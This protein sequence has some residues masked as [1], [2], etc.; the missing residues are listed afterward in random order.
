[1]KLQR[2][3]PGFYDRK[4]TVEEIKKYLLPSAKQLLKQIA[5]AYA[6]SAVPEQIQALINQVNMLN[7]VPPTTPRWLLGLYGIYENGQFL[8]VE[9]SDPNWSVPQTA[10]NYASSKWSVEVI[11]RAMYF[12]LSLTLYNMFYEYDK[13]TPVNTYNLALEETFDPI[14]KELTT[15]RNFVNSEE[16]TEHAIEQMTA[17]LQKFGIV[18]E[19]NRVKR[20]QSGDYVSTYIAAS[21]Y[22]NLY[23][24]RGQEEDEDKAEEIYREWLNKPKPVQ[25]D[26]ASLLS[27][28]YVRYDQLHATFQGLPVV[29]TYLP[30][31]EYDPLEFV[32]PLNELGNVVAKFRVAWG[33]SVFEQAPMAPDELQKQAR[34]ILKEHSAPFPYAMTPML[35]LQDKETWGILKQ[36]ILNLLKRDWDVEEQVRLK[37]YTREESESLTIL[38]NLKNLLVRLEWFIVHGLPRPD[39]VYNFDR[40]MS[41]EQWKVLKRFLDAV[42]M[43]ASGDHVLKTT[44]RALESAKSLQVP[45]QKY[46]RQVIYAIMALVDDLVTVDNIE[47]WQ[48]S[49]KEK[50]DILSDTE[51]LIVQYTQE[52][53]DPQDDSLFK[54]LKKWV[55]GGPWLPWR[56]KSKEEVPR[57]ILDPDFTLAESTLNVFVKSKEPL[58]DFYIGKIN[59]NFMSALGEF[60][61]KATPMSQYQEDILEQALELSGQKGINK[62]ELIDSFDK[63]EHDI[64]YVPKSIY[65]EIQHDLTKACVLLLQIIENLFAGIAVF[66]IQTIDA[67]LVEL[68]ALDLLFGKNYRV[69]KGTGEIQWG[70][71]PTQIGAPIVTEDHVDWDY[72][73]SPSIIEPILDRVQKLSPAQRQRLTDYITLDQMVA[74]GMIRPDIGFVTGITHST[75]PSLTKKYIVGHQ[76]PLTGYYDFRLTLEEELRLLNKWQVVSKLLEQLEKGEPA[77]PV[78][79][80]QL[81]EGR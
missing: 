40:G 24:V 75:H 67:Y 61:S 15:P 14:W 22:I 23:L 9:Q 52:L 57:K 77:D 63:L 41:L 59:M 51:G 71:F 31:R 49:A 55:S 72:S 81:N 13:D 66:N 6:Q 3:P 58:D 78:L 27:Q 38:D 26:W 43:S 32:V 34:E 37:I 62:W 46:M 76:N 8:Y 33:R 73:A 21:K 29:Y 30:L 45:E 17:A 68:E 5:E 74:I 56:G 39:K 79:Q 1:M 80:K 54:K 48:V 20:I 60:L 42:G 10:Y 69:L 64:L 53:Q 35:H 47:T 50:I 18:D 19:F 65:L 70:T 44:W 28:E 16:T 4:L 2:L 25:F 11:Q 7:Y 12:L 36:Q